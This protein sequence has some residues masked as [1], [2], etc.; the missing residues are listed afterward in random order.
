[1]HRSSESV[2]ALATALAK[3][4]I[5]LVNPEK[6]LTGTF[7]SERRGE[8][9]RTFRYAPLASG[10]DVVRKTLGK[11][12]LAVMQTTVVDQSNRT[13]N[14][15]TLLAHSSGEWISSDWP[16]CPVADVAVPHRMGAALTYARRYALF[17][18]VGIAGEDDLDAPDLIVERELP[19]ASIMA[20][21]AR[22]DN[23]HGHDAILGRRQGATKRERAI[24]N[25]EQSGTERD[26]LISQISDLSTTE[27]AS[28]WAREALPIKNKLT[29]ADAQLLEQTF[30]A[31]VANFSETE[32]ADSESAGN[33]MAVLDIAAPAATQ[34]VQSSCEGKRDQTHQSRSSLSLPRRRDKAHLKYVAAQACLVCGRQPSDPHHLR[35]AQV[36]TLGRKVSDEF[37]VP[38][39]RS[40]HSELHRSSAERAWWD[41]LGIDPMTTAR[42]LW[43]KTHGGHHPSGLTGTAAEQPPARKPR[44]NGKIKA[45]ADK[46]SQSIASA[47]AHEFAKAD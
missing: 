33:T 29:T 4:Q 13:I 7:R 34:Q 5:E 8:G 37:V 27:Q 1:V 45:A 19:Q 20:A 38:L 47:S 6:S 17:A 43:I 44:R 22:S 39:C 10:L 3:A 11:H 42:R 30:A 26:R 2:A 23:S 31:R 12:E 25:P 32:H 24:L 18:L 9:D 46:L 14:L 16:V 28:R 21:G 40:H 36:A 41:R 35:F 15:T